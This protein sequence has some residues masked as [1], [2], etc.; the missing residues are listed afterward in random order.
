MDIHSVNESNEA[1]TPVED[2]V[3]MEKVE[4]LVET[5]KLP[6][7]N[8]SGEENIS[9]EAAEMD[10]EAKENEIPSPSYQELLSNTSL[11]S[12]K[13]TRKAAKA[14][15]DKKMILSTDGQGKTRKTSTKTKLRLPAKTGTLSQLRM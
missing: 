5:E 4:V 10:G 8:V 11:K 14:K 3:A 2:G 7:K 6:V 1:L 15:E 12:N 13:G 9:K